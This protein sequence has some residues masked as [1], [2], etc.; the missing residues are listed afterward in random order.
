MSLDSKLP[1]HR[2]DMAVVPSRPHPVKGKAFRILL[3]LALVA[4]AIIHIY[5]GL[6]RSKS[7]EQQLP[8]PTPDK[9]F[10]WEDIT[11]TEQLVYHPCFDHYGCARLSLPMDWNR[12]DGEGSKIALAVIKVPAKV[13]VTDA[14]YGGAILLNPGGPGGSGVSLVLRYG[15]AIQTIVDSPESPSADSASGK[16]FDVVS[17]DPRGVNNTTPNLSCFPDSATRKAWLLQLEAEGLLGSSEGAFDTRWARYEAFGMSCNQQGVTASKDGEWI[18]KFM[19][20]AP[21]VADMV[22]LVE[23]QGEWRERE[24]ERL[25]ST[26]S[27]TSLAEANSDAERIS[28]HNRW[29]KGEEKLLYWGFSYGT[30]LG[31]T[32]AAMQ[33][34]R[35]HR[36]VIDGVCN[37]DDYYAGNWLTNLQDSD[38]AFDKFFEYCQTAGPSSCAFALGG[39]PEDLKSRYEQLLTNLT[40]SPIAVPPSGNRGP[41]I[42]TYSDVKSL[43]VQALYTPLKS[44]DLVARLLTELEQGNGSSFADLKY[45]AKQ[46]PAPPPCDS[47][48]Q[49]KVPGE[50]DQEASRNILCTDGPGLDGTAKEEFRSYWNRL[51]GQSKAVGDFWA[52]IRM[53]CV[54]METRPEWRYDGNTSHPLLF[55]GNTYDP[56]TPLRNA[57]TMARGFPESIVL[58]QNSIGHCTLSGPSL[59]TAKAIRQYFQTGELPS[60]GT[61]CQVD[62]LPFHLAGQERSQ[63]LSPGD[64]ELM[65][66]LHSLSEVRHPLGAWRG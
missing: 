32:F 17:F 34:H 39:D 23:R 55:I 40:S 13:P 42:I 57:H 37:A 29:N 41:E 66:A 6:D 20:T 4:F 14:R 27:N 52:E 7:V 62:E 24:T 30:I 65:S 35:I 22:E 8:S 51:Q 49:Y 26:D 1:G 18:G 56:V 3:L 46:W 60:P 19:N 9:S 54:R 28:L 12:T 50:S 38:E 48:K 10:E 33:P 15:K 43:V 45:E 5:G 25:L 59:C 63:I 31:S 21:V 11:P 61:V 53:S 64:T 44:F 58:E 47:S 36:A 2:P 16:Y